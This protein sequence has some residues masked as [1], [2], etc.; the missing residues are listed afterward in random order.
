M[1]CIKYFFFNSI[2]IPPINDENKKVMD[3]KII[4]STRIILLIFL[5][6]ISSCIEK[7]T[8]S[9]QPTSEDENPLIKN[10]VTQKSMSFCEQII[11]NY[12]NIDGVNL[13]IRDNCSFRTSYCDTDG[14]MQLNGNLHTGAMQIKINNAPFDKNYCLSK[15]IHDCYYIFNQNSFSYNCDDKISSFFKYAEQVQEIGLNI[16][17]H[18]SWSKGDLILDFREF[19][20]GFAFEQKISLKISLDWINYLIKL[21]RKTDNL[22]PGQ[23]LDCEADITIEKNQID[24]QVGFVTINIDDNN[25]PINNGCMEW[26]NDCRNDGCNLDSKHNYIITSENKLY[27]NWF[28]Q[29]DNDLGIN[30]Y[31]SIFLE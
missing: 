8:L 17:N 1:S 21:N 31:P 12:K 7:Q 11:G 9:V 28:G 14:E 2:N 3:V 24:D 10:G 13:S 4:K 18:W 15:G 22:V 26:D 25:D 30:N 16:F 19:K 27:I 6:I 5:L 23:I 20:Y 29:L